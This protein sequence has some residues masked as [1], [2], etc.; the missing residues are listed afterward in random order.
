ML[1]S[2][3]FL[4]VLLQ[5][6]HWYVDFANQTSDEIHYKGTYADWRGVTHS[7]KHGIGTFLCVWIITGWEN[8]EFAFGLALLDIFLHYHIDWVKTNFAHKDVTSPIF[9]NHFGLDQ[10]AHQLCYIM[11]IG[12]ILL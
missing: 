2:I 3:L 1:D 12:I 10:L 6:K 4:L 7:L 11:Y 8:V 5:C 9:W